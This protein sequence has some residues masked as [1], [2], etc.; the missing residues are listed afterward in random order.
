MRYLTDQENLANLE[1]QLEKEERKLY[2][3]LKPS[4][5]EAA[6]LNRLFLVFNVE[7]N[8]VPNIL[9]TIKVTD[10]WIN[11]KEGA[12][13]VLEDLETGQEIELDHVPV[14][15]FHFEAFMSIP[16][17]SKVR[18][19]ARLDDDNIIRRSLVFPVLIAAKSRNGRMGS[20]GVYVETPKRFMEK[21]PGH[22]LPLRHI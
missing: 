19:D 11:A 1:I 12:V 9:T 22:N 7:E 5:I 20:G 17:I 3:E 2:R 10:F 13:A 15:L 14:R 16:P 21:F 8:G 4:R 18:W 6:F